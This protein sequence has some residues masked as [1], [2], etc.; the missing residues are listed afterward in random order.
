VSTNE[1]RIE[2]T[3]LRPNRL[4]YHRLS[5]DG[6]P[7]NY[8]CILGSIL[9]PTPSGVW[10]VWLRCRCR[11]PR[12]AAGEAWEVWCKQTSPGVAVSGSWRRRERLGPEFYSL[13]H[14]YTHIG[15]VNKLR[16]GT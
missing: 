16:V 5:T 15:L 9:Q 12:A 3:L 4:A 13:Q 1:R 11:G 7:A 6:G 10:S 14:T 8:L 2:A